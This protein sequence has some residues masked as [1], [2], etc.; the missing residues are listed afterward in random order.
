MFFTWNLGK[1]YWWM[2][3]LKLILWEIFLATWITFSGVYKVDAFLVYFCVSQFK[4][5]P[6]SWLVFTATLFSKLIYGWIISYFQ[7]G[8]WNLYWWW[9]CGRRGVLKGVTWP[10]DM[11]SLISLAEILNKSIWGKKLWSGT[12]TRF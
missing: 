4:E 10:I 9:L 5:K 6:C 11:K 8:L 1:T 3:Y 2:I 7:H 12:S